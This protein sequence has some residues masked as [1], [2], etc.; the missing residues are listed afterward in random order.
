MLFLVVV[1]EEKRGFL[2]LHIKYVLLVLFLGKMIY[3]GFSV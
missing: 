3:T 1:G 2:L